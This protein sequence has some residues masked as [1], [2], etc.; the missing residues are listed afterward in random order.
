MQKQMIVALLVGASALAARGADEWPA[1]TMDWRAGVESPAD[2]SFLLSAPAGKDGFITVKD[3]HFVRPDGSRLRIWGINATGAAGLPDKA[4]APVIAAALARRGINCIRF[5]FLDKVGTLIAADR[6]DTRTLDPQALDR[7]DRFVFELKQ[8]GIYADLNLNVYRT[9]KP[10]DGVRDCVPLGIAKGA[11]YFDAR[12][13][14]LQREYARQLLTHTNAYTGHAYREEPAVAVVE[15]VNENSLVEA[16]TQNRLVGT[17]TSKPT[18]TWH[19]IPPSYAA[20]LTQQYNAWLPQHVTAAQLAAWRD[21][22]GLVPRLRKEEFAKADP[23]R[24]NAEASFYMDVESGFFRGMAK[25]L[26]E[27]L[28]VKNLLIGDSDH[29]H[30]MSGYPH[31]AAL[32]Q[33]DAVDGHVY[34]QHPHYLNDPRSKRRSGFSIPNTP[35]VDDPPHSSVVQLSRTAVV[36]KPFTI[37]EANH[38]FPAE[39]A[40]EG[41]PV[42]AAYAALQDWDGIFWYSLAHQDVTT[43]GQS[44]LAYFDFAKDAVKMNQLARLPADLAARPRGARQLVRWPAD[45]RVRA[46]GDQQHHIG[47]RR[48]DLARERQG[49]R[50]RCRGYAALAGADRP[51]R[52]AARCD[53][54]PARRRAD[55]VHRHHARCAR[56]PAHRH[57]AAPPPD[58]RLAHGEQRHDVE[59]E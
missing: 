15:F 5:H 16:W 18:D 22:S 26:R 47:H 10:G 6:D 36:G 48:T 17:Q 23:A 2:V 58:G 24:F 33:L 12:L 49:D 44:A 21:A 56:C 55:A 59:C 41:V 13:L 42:L 54:K 52:D 9:Y 50:P 32:A 8:R 30:G 43:M 28:G 3:G 29:N 51:P 40:C 7:L 19:D 38:P 14:E 37:T 1:F 4:N 20:D 27:E 45:G 57:G 25:F 39:F 46:G 35:M 31:V 11:T 53:E 34:W